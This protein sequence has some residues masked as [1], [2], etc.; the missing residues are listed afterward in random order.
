[1]RNLN[2]VWFVW[3]FGFFLKKKK[4][5]MS[6]CVVQPI[7]VCLYVQILLLAQSADTLN[8]S[9]WRLQ[10]VSLLYHTLCAVQN[11]ILFLLESKIIFTSFFFFCEFWAFCFFGG[12]VGFLWFVF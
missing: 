2:L 10:S 12:G 6:Y 8:M 9:L 7:A 3:L 4:L 1:M 11:C 5:K